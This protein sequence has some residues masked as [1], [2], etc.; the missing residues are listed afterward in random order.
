VNKVTGFFQ[1]MPLLL[2]LWRTVTLFDLVC[3]SPSD[4]IATGKGNLL[5]KAW[6]ATPLRTQQALRDMMTMGPKPDIGFL[7][8]GPN[9]YCSMLL[10]LAT[11]LGPTSAS[12]LASKL[13]QI[14]DSSAR[15]WFEVCLAGDNQEL[16]D[17]Q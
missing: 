2:V 4:S 1:P 17:C 14:H 11:A 5:P 7:E 13:N 12:L 3:F 16:E 15:F 6:A 9:L 10:V 8:F